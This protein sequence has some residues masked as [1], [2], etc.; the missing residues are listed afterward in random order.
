MNHSTRHLLDSG[1]DHSRSKSQS[2]HV[3]FII[4]FLVL[5]LFI[6]PGEVCFETV[7]SFVLNMT[8][9]SGQ[10]QHWAPANTCEIHPYYILG[11]I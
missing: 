9:I 6:L 8:C 4:F 1:E 3:L 2:A 7:N 11:L 10:Q 5:T